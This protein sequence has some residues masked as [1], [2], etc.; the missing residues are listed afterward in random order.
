MINI[1]RVRLPNID[2]SFKMVVDVSLPKEIDSQAEELLGV[3]NNQGISKGIT[4]TKQKPENLREFIQIF[5]NPTPKR[6]EFFCRKDVS[7]DVLIK[8]CSR[9]MNNFLKYNLF[10][11]SYL[12]STM[13]YFYKQ[14]SSSL[15]WYS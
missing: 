2:K 14:Y 12:L 8:Q 11:A 15:F 7:E 3:T 5:H 1:S 4:S 9:K 13:A 6:V 10:V